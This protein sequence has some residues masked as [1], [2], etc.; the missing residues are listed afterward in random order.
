MVPIAAHARRA[1]WSAAPNFLDFGVS[2]PDCPPEP[3]E[4]GFLN[5][6]TTPIVVTSAEIG[7]GSMDGEFSL[8][9]GLG[10][11][12]TLA[13]GDTLTLEA[14]YAAQSRGL[15]ASPL[16]VS[17]AALPVPLLVPLI[18]ESTT[19]VDVVD[20]FVQTDGQKVDVLFVVDNTGSMIEEQPRFRAAL[21]AFAGAAQARG[22]DMHVAITTTGI[23]PVSPDCPGGARGGEAGRLFPADGSTRRLLTSA[24][25][26]LGAALQANA[27]VGLCAVVEKG[28]EAVRRALSPPL[29]NNAERS[30]HPAPRR[31]QPRLPARLGLAGG[32]LRGR[33]GRSLARRRGHLRAVPAR[34]EGRRTAAAGDDPRH[35]PGRRAAAAR[36]GGEGLRYA[37]AV[38]Q[39][40]G[41]VL[42]AC[43][44]D[45]AP[46]LRRI[47]E[48]SLGPQHS[49]PLSAPADA[50]SIEVLLDGSPLSSGWDYD[51]RHQRHRLRHRACR[52]GPDPGPL[53]ADL[54][55]IVRRSK[56]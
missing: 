25:G 20:D 52:R 9:R 35:R 6:C 21:P 30:A 2:R 32:G 46:L 39:T 24:M 49:F 27:E 33:R 28:F 15:N 53:P 17:T 11:P 1:A 16:F 45:Y 8:T 5:Q 43:A 48:Q 38:R 3:R 12:Q 22:V 34:A 26:D 41:S 56:T 23:E 18:G 7:P 19:R 29:V 4:V 37:E 31:R 36:A 51:P 54:R 14:A 55:L 47:A 42:S 40:G 13:P 50:S 10:G 44:A